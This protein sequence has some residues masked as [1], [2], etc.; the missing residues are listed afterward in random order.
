LSWTPYVYAAQKW[1]QLR[2]SQ[3][4]R[5]ERGDLPRRAPLFERV[6]HVSMPTVFVL[7][8][9]A[10]GPA[11]AVK[12]GDYFGRS[13]AGSSTWLDVVGDAHLCPALTPSTT[14]A[15]QSCVIV[16]LSNGQAVTR[17]IDNNTDQLSATSL[18]WSAPTPGYTSTTTWF[19]AV[20]PVNPPHTR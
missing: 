19:P 8:T 10:A 12:A 16:A 9:I 11:L 3:P 7:L 20:L 15:H 4:V 1:G 18:T 5:H 14:T 13:E 6:V 2:P 17:W